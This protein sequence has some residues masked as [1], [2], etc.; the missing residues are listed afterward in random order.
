MPGMR[1]L[2]LALASLLAATAAGPAG[3]GDGELVEIVG[4]VDERGALESGNGIW[5]RGAAEEPIL[6]IG[7]AVPATMARG[8]RVRI[9]GVRG[10]DLT[11]RGR[12]GILRRYEV[13]QAT[14]LHA[15]PSTEGNGWVYWPLL[16]LLAA[17]LLLT[18][19][20]G[21]RSAARPT[22]RREFEHAWTS[23]E[24][25]DLPE[26]PAEAL[27]VLAQRADEERT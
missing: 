7:E 23:L 12:D 5:V 16:M 4:V 24:P 1:L 26:D 11:A 17:A 19:R 10:E 3:G 15:V 8:Q 14:T 25:T 2:L 21:G 18:M 13:L 20:F 6:V 27:A 22:P 9:H